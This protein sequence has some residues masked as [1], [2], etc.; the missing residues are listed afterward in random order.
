MN[1]FPIG[2]RIIRTENEAYEVTKNQNWLFIMC[3]LFTSRI[4]KNAAG[5]DGRIS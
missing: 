2:K 5:I 1:Y 3:S 4:T